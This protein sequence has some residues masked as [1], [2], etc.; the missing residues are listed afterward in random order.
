MKTS[1]QFTFHS[2]SDG[3]TFGVGELPAELRFTPGM[4]ETLWQLQPVDSPTIRLHGRLVKIPR[5]QQAYGKDYHFSGQTS[6]ALALPD[7]LT[8]I[9]AWV[10]NHIDNRL[11]GLL[12]NW[13]DGRLGH[14]IGKHRDSRVN[15]VHRAPIITI[16]FGEERAFRLAPWRQRDRAAVDFSAR[17]GTVFIMP[18]ETNLAWTHS[19]PAS[20]L[21]SGR[22][23][24]VTFRAFV[25]SEPATTKR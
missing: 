12:V 7:L 25:E 11:N 23:I 17:D 13:Y 16:S 18:Y 6:V 10:R 3:L 14:Y 21:R 24:S 22:R 2:L 9:L 19:V 20:R 4:F 5:K 8:P 15:I 1:K